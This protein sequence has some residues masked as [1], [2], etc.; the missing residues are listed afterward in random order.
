MPERDRTDRRTFL[1][2]ATFGLA[3]GAVALAGETDAAQ[4]ASAPEGEEALYRE[5]D[6]VRRYYEVARF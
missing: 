4:A 2:L 6:H 1:K 3:G 5:S